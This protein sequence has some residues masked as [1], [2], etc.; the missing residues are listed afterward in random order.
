[1]RGQ[2]KLL[3]RD[4]KNQEVTITRSLQ[5]QQKAKTLQLSTLDQTIQRRNQAGEVG[6]I[7]KT[8]FSVRFLLKLG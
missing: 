8:I 5:V 4:V 7:L 6:H 3:F 1:M 2:I